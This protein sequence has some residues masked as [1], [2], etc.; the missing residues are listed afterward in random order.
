VQKNE[1]PDLSTYEMRKYHL[2]NAE[3]REDSEGGSQPPINIVV[4]KENDD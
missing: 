4:C 3:K 2:R 1:Q